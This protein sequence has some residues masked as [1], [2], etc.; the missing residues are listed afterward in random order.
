MESGRTVVAVMQPYFAPYAGYYRLLAA[1]DI[2]VIFDC[3]Q[4]PR[5]GWVHRNRLP[6]ARGE[7]AWLTLPLAGAAFD[8]PIRDIVFAPDAEAGMVERLRSFPSMAAPGE[9]AA[10]FLR[11]GPF[12]GPLVDYLEAQLRVAADLLG[13][14]PRFIRSS[15]LEIPPELRA[16]DRV[17]AIL[18]HLGAT[19]YVNAPGGRD[20]YQDEV[21]AA[22]GVALNFLPPYGG[23][24]WSLLHR[25]AVEPPGAVAEEIRR[26]TPPVGP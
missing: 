2:F 19:H 5:R 13:L 6:D 10:A 21:F 24:S 23:P 16:Q 11:A 17:L 8:A 25:L 4:F 12:A 14:G 15:S 1:A 9:A 26:E 20:L 22:A 7:P 18:A 3:V